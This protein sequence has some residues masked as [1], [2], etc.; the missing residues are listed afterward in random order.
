MTRERMRSDEFLVTQEF[1]AMMLDVQRAGVS[2]AVGALQKLSY[3][4]YGV[5]KN[6]FDRLLNE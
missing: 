2:I 5:S 6:E 3:E 4:C 1:L